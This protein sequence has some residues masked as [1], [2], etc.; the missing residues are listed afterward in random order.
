MIDL[1][2]SYSVVDSS[3]S[4]RR[5]SVNMTSGADWAMTDAVAFSD[6]SETSSATTFASLRAA[7]TRGRKVGHALVGEMHGAEQ[8]GRRAA[9]LLDLPQDGAGVLGRGGLRH[10]AGI[11]LRILGGRLGQHVDAAALVG[12]LGVLLGG[13]GAG[14]RKGGDGQSGDS[15]K[16]KR[17][18]M[19]LLNSGATGVGAPRR[20][21]EKK[22][23]NYVKVSRSFAKR[24]NSQGRLRSADGLRHRRRAAGRGRPR[25]RPAWSTGRRGRA[26]PGSAA[27]RRRPTADAWRT[28]GAARAASPWRASRGA[29]RRRSM[30]SWMRRGRQ[31]AALGAA[32][33]RLVRLQR[34]GAELHV[35]GDGLAH[36]GE[37]RHQPLLAALAVDAQHVAIGRRRV[38]RA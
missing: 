38:L 23:Q 19:R 2:A 17:K 28:N 22:R 13:A 29:S 8:V 26:A 32:E 16:G 12:G 36:D 21:A 7:L 5:P 9:F 18:R 1:T 11:G 3:V 34:I 31:R 24:L 33:Q 30:A 6:R 14:W 4:R 15:A 20:P 10:D 35:A 27:G 37:H 25:Y